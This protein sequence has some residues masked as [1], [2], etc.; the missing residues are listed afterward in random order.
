VSLSS[1][2]PAVAE[3]P[4]RLIHVRNPDR[5]PSWEKPNMLAKYYVTTA[6]VALARRNGGQKG[7]IS[8][9]R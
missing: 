6:G 7:E 8:A 3:Q 1:S 5:Q 4:L 2:T 9:L